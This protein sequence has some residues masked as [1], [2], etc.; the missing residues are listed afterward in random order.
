MGFFMQKIASVLHMLIY[1][2]RANSPMK[3]KKYL[4]VSLVILIGILDSFPGTAKGIHEFRSTLK[5]RIITKEIKPNHQ[6]LA[7]STAA[8]Y[9]NAAQLFRSGRYP[10]A[11]A[12]FSRILTNPSIDVNTKNNALLGRAQSFLI[13]NQATLAISD[14]AKVNYK[15]AE[16]NLI[17]SK[18]L[19][20]GVAYI[21]VKQYPTA[22]KHLT[23]AIKYLPNDESAYSNRSVAYQAIKNYD[24]AALDLE[25]SLQINPTPSSIYNLAVLEKERKNYTRCF[26]LLLEIEKQ[27]AGAYADVFLQRGL[28]AKQLNKPEQ[29]LKDF[30]KAASLD[31]TNAEAVA[32]IG[33]TVAIMGDKKTALKY[34]ERASALYLGQGKI[35]KFEEVNS[36]MMSISN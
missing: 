29:A 13:I 1:E 31:K 9:E 27:N 2:R 3:P 5:G 7:Q 24:A 26:N 20:L 32:N 17:G 14:L 25:K 16:K 30:L 34:L 36:K 15:S 18:E 12:I 11:I 10:E 35:S 22:I 4:I 28:C 19:I 8:D 23:K 6:L 33:Y 21:Q